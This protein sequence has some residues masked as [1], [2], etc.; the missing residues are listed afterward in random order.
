MNVEKLWSKLLKR[1]LRDSLDVAEA[2]VKRLEVENDRLRKL[3]ST[4]IG[5]GDGGGNLYVHGDYDSI[6]AVH[7]L[8]SERDELANEIS[9]RQE[10]IEN[11]QV[12]NRVL[13]DKVEE[14]R[15]WW[16]D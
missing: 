15:R 14:L 7:R 4:T 11:M 12:R 13:G 1:S 3:M 9:L 16:G 8:V 10:V 6:K 5:M 2:N